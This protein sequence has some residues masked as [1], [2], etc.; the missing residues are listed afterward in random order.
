MTSSKTPTYLE[1]A[2]P[3]WDELNA[4]LDKGRRWGA[5]GLSAEELDRLDRLYRLTTIHLA[6]ARLRTT[7]RALIEGLDR[8]VARAHSFIYVSPKKN[9]L[10]RL[11]Q[12]YLTGFSR[13]VA[14]TWK[15]QLA[16]LLLFAV[17]AVVAQ[18][19]AMH[20]AIP[21]YALLGGDVR[22]PGSSP[23]QLENVLRS[24]RDW[25]AHRKFEFASFL[26]THN[27][28]VGFMAF[29]MGILGGIPTVFLIL[30]NGA[31]LG[32][33]A[34]V[35]YRHGIVAEM[36]AWLL[37]HGIT[38]LSAVILCGGAGL[39]LGMALLHPGYATRG[40]S[41]LEAGREAAR[42]VMGVVPMFIMAGF[43]ESYLRQSTLTT[44]T[45]LIFAGATA[46]LWAVYFYI[47]FYLEAR[48]R[49]LA[50]AA[51]PGPQDPKEEL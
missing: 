31:M 45:R 2:R 37:P 28:K 43:I 41:V 48:D 4:L 46:V 51:P 17:G 32:A 19:A 10:T 38:E 39:M 26:L 25:S 49:R 42:I 14:R 7:N 6:Q 21:A 8:L 23:E 36:W 16:S 11:A 44:E 3:I 5:R 40:R 15:F 18:Y 33:F 13:A 12:F 20:D 9:P 29:A 22:L 1:K 30:T 34:A 27:T 35:H 24:G 47:G 50:Q